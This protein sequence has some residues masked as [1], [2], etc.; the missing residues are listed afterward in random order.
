MPTIEIVSLEC[1]EVPDLPTFTSFAYL[2]EDRL[3]SHRALFQS[4]FDGISGV[5]IHVGNK[6]L[7]QDLDRGEI[8]MWW[9][10]GL[11]EWGQGE[12]TIPTINPDLGG[13][14]RWG[15]GQVHMFRFLP[16]VIPDLRRLLTLLREHS[17]LKQAYFSTDLQLGPEKV[18]QPVW[19]TISTLFEIHKHW[20]LRWNTL[21]R[22]I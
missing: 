6:E 18:V 5:I 21:Y 8:S 15:E 3:Q 2:A 16:H 10:G 19:Y 17:P 13:D 12:I 11:I 4:E 1:R 22:V 9:A 20:G 7:Q 14:Q